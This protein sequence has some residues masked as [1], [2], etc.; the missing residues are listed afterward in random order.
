M[1]GE[2]IQTLRASPLLAPLTEAEYMVLANCGRIYTYA[3]GETILQADGQDER[4]FIL[5]DGR[6]ALHLFMCMDGGECGG[7]E[8][9]EL[10]LPGEAFGWA[11][12]VRPDRIG[13][14]AHALGSVSA[15]VLELNRLEDSLTFLKISQRMVQSLYGWLQETGLCP[16]NMHVLLKL[17][18]MQDA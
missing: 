11:T 4:M 14:S 3:P 18:H 2:V 13:V 9:L 8:T 5:R 16:P 15:V 7:E 17:G 6:L 10:A 12:W 1:S